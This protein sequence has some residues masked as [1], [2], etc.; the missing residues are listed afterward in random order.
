MRSLGL[1]EP[2]AVK[3]MDSG[4]FRRMDTGFY[5]GAVLWAVLN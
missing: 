5:V 3:L 1:Y 4:A 2:A